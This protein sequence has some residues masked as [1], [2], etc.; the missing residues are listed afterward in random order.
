MKA[1]LVDLLEKEKI[2]SA[3]FL[4]NVYEEVLKRMTDRVEKE[5]QPTFCLYITT[6]VDQA[7][8]AQSAKRRRF[9]QEQQVEDL[10]L[11]KANLKERFGEDI[12][13]P[14]FMVP[15]YRL[16]SRLSKSQY[17]FIP[18]SEFLVSA[19]SM[20]QSGIKKPRTSTP[21]KPCPS[22]WVRLEDSD[23]WKTGSRLILDWNEADPLAMCA[24]LAR[25]SR[26]SAKKGP[27][28]AMVFDHKY[29]SS[30]LG[31]KQEGY[32]LSDVLSKDLD[33]SLCISAQIGSLSDVEGI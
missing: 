6:L 2:Y 9:E 3:L 15:Q 19:A 10:S 24:Y 12:D 8:A 7:K 11:Y 5:Q 27:Q 16:L 21:A 17:D 25:I 18:A 28:A 20:E 30:L 33:P 31:Y 22:A 4:A 1:I 29:R 26:L 14:F 23:R 13:A 32:S